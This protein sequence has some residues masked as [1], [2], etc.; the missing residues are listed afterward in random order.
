MVAES[1]RRREEW[2]TGLLF[3]FFVCLLAQHTAYRGWMNYS[4]H[5]EQPPFHSFYTPY[6]AFHTIASALLVLSPAARST[7]NSHHAVRVFECLM[8]PANIAHTRACHRQHWIRTVTPRACQ[9]VRSGLMTHI[10]P[11]LFRPTGPRA[12]HPLGPP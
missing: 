4:P 12:L 6:D 9:S 1:E 8:T 2:G 3:V 10:L 5:L 7:R 11:S